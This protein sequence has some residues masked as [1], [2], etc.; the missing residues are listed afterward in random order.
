MKKLQKLLVVLVVTTITLLTVVTHA[1][2]V[3]PQFVQDAVTAGWSLDRSVNSCFSLIDKI[4]QAETD[5]NF[6][7]ESNGTD[8][9]TPT[10]EEL[11]A[12]QNSVSGSS[13]PVHGSI[14][15]LSKQNISGNASTGTYTTF[16]G[17]HYFFFSVQSV[18]SPISCTNSVLCPAV[19]FQLQ[20]QDPATLNWVNLCQ[21]A[22]TRGTVVS[23]TTVIGT[24]SGM[25][26]VFNLDLGGS[27]RV[28]YSLLNG[29]TGA[30]ISIGVSY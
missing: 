8:L 14:I 20:L 12:L 3:Y 30:I 24:A 4:Y 22:D 7:T 27:W 2:P 21:C 29:A 9:R 6:C 5:W 25:G 11:T 1:Q 23:P 10:A 28:L 18:N 16:P 13:L 19:G 17:K 26:T 15:L